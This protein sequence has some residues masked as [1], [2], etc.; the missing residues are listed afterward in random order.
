MVEIII[1]EYRPKLL[2]SAIVILIARFAIMFGV[3]SE[4]FPESPPLFFRVL[5]VILGIVGLIAGIWNFTVGVRF[6]KAF[7]EFVKELKLDDK[8]LVLPRTMKL[9]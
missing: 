8:T 9:V 6:S 7:R 2:A 4:R 5:S 1:L 3:F